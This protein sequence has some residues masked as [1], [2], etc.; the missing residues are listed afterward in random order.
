M[1]QKTFDFRTKLYIF[2]VPSTLLGRRSWKFQTGCFRPYGM[3]SS[4]PDKNF[5]RIGRIFFEIPSAQNY[6][7]SQKSTSKSPIDRIPC[8]KCPKNLKKLIWR[9]GKWFLPCKSFFKL[10]QNLMGKFSGKTDF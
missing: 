7:I 8:R 10:V 5:R 2:L 1:G 4:K 6:F 3:T 9:S